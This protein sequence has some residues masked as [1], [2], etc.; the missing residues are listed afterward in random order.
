MIRKIKFEPARTEFQRKLSEDLRSN[1]RFNKIFVFADKTRNMYGLDP[2]EYDK[3]LN[4]N[5][6]K[7]YKKSNIK[8]VNEINK[9]ANVLTEKLKIN[10]RVHCIAQNEAF[11][12]IKDHKPNFPKN[13]ACRLLNPCKSEIG[14]ISKVYLENTNNSIRGFNNLNQKHK[15]KFKKVKFKNC[16]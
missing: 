8:T 6:T 11:T 12:T 3:L 9:E 5:V 4:N 15:K 14:E 2:K 7:S 1:K 16:Y 10:D 13:V